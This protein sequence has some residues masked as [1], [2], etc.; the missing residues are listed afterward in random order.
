[1]HEKLAEILKNVERLD[2]ERKRV[3]ESLRAEKFETNEAYERNL[4][5][6]LT[7][8]EVN[9]K[10]VAVDGGLLAQEFH[11][12]DLVVA[13]AVGVL[14]EYEKGKLGK[15]AY[16]PCAFPEVEMDVLNALDTHEVNWHKSLFRLKKEL[17]IATESVEKFEPDYL[18]LDGS[19]APLVSDRPDDT[20]EVRGLYDQV[21][22]RYKK[23]YET[24]EKKKCSLV[25]VIKDSRGKRFI[26]IIGK[27]FGQGEEGL[28]KS[29]DTTF[30]Q[31]FL[32]EGERTFAFP[33]GSD[34]KRHQVLKDL[35][36]WG[37]KVGAFYLRP[38]E[39]D[40][41]IRVEFVPNGRS[42]TEIADLVYSLS[43]INRT[44]AY[45]AVLIEADLRAALERIELERT[46]RDMFMRVGR[47]G[48][49]MKLRRDS[50]PFR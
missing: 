40:R 23:L 31:F 4:V 12:F 49:A 43:T 33:Y 46:V 1:M 41:P 38:V 28:A 16:H 17:E 44:Y 26:E 13:R 9:A 15:H 19:V 50:R 20:S 45:P 11:G 24:C 47:T 29:T 27:K 25:G 21:I 36:E 48:S 2:G 37:A 7:Q 8:R 22:G 34:A 39:G 30:L 18:M 14:F 6:P 32:R 35:G 5:M 3:A 10:V 42:Y